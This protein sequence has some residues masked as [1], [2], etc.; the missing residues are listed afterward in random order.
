MPIIIIVV[1]KIPRSDGNLTESIKRHILRHIFIPLNVD[2]R[3]YG[4]H[5][6]D[7]NFF[8]YSVCIRRFHD[9]I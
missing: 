6:T 1:R 9:C 7:L 4:D 3:E 2:L 8:I 5:G